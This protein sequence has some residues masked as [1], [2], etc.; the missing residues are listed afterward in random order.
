MG[1][2]SG[3]RKFPG[4]LLSLAQVRFN[5]CG[6]LDEAGHVLSLRWLSGNR[7]SVTKVSR[8]FQSM[9]GYLHRAA[10]A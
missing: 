10:Q 9:V 6:K 8:H 4:G 1:P 5:M 7:F 2:T 3:S